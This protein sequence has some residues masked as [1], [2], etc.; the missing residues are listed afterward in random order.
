MTKEPKPKKWDFTGTQVMK[1]EVDY[2]LED[3]WRDMFKWFKDTWGG[4]LSP[5][6]QEGGFNLIWVFL[7]LRANMENLEAIKKLMTKKHKPPIDMEVLEFLD[8]L[9][10]KDIEILRGIKQR[11]FLD[12]FEPSLTQSYGNEE[13]AVDTTI[14]FVNSYIQEH[15]QKAMQETRGKKKPSRGYTP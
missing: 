4:K 6:K 1:G 3:Y 2:T 9:H 10:K 12:F 8:S 15:I 5:E 13:Q 14:A 7:S 11:L